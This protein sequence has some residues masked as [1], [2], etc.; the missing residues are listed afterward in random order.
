MA[1]EIAAGGDDDRWLLRFSRWRLFQMPSTSYSKRVKDMLYFCTLR[2]RSFSNRQNVES[3]QLRGSPPEGACLRDFGRQATWRWETM[4]TILALE[5]DP[6]NTQ[7]FSALDLVKGLPPF[8][9]NVREGGS[10]GWKPL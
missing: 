10:R 4:K 9:S 5:D 2:S 3:R 6:S 1:R 8:G 7:A